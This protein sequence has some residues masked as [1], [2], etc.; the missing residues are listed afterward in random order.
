MKDKI[1]NYISNFIL[2]QMAEMIANKLNLKKDIHPD[3]ITLDRNKIEEI[4]KDV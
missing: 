1:N 4:G 3:W 2:I